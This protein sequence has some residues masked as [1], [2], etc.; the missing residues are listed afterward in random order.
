MFDVPVIVTT[1]MTGAFFFVSLIFS[2]TSPTTMMTM[3]EIALLSQ[4][5]GGTECN[6]SC[7][8]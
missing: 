4:T 8:N 5:F 7:Q 3:T 2:G 1:V 6:P